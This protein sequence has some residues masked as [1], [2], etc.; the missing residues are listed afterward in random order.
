[1]NH[2]KI[3][4]H[5]E[6][7]ETSVLEEFLFCFVLYFVWKLPK[8]SRR[9]RHYHVYVRFLSKKKI[10][11]LDFDKRRKGGSPRRDKPLAKENWCRLMDYFL[12]SQCRKIVVAMSYI[13]Y[14][15]HVFF[16]TLFITIFI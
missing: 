8:L 13:S 16:D 10:N 6:F 3:F 5:L 12:A 11:L 1:M 14:L 2:K 15:F 7:V 9:F 4:L